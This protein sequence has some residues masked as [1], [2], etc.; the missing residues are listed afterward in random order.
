MIEARAPTEGG[1]SGVRNALRLIKRHKIVIVA[2]IVVFAGIAWTIRIDQRAALL[3][4]FGS[5]TEC[6][7][8]QNCRLRGGFSAP[9]RNFYDQERTRCHTLAFAQRGGLSSLG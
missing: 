4:R 9:A 8:G 1:L 5:H 7:Q 6:G 3:R 2:P